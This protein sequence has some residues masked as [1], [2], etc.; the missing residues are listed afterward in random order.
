MQRGNNETKIT[1]CKNKKKK[2]ANKR[3]EL[4]YNKVGE[5]LVNI[6]LCSFI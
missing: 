6:E 2:H 1:K 4:S 3:Y 5:I